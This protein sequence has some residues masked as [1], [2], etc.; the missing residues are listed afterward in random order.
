MHPVPCLE[1]IEVLSTEG[2]PQNNFSVSDLGS[3]DSKL[4]S[5]SQICVCH[6]MVV[7]SAVFLLIVLDIHLGWTKYDCIYP[8]I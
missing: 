1:T 2:E 8:K 7:W 6:L 5:Q 4:L 3:K